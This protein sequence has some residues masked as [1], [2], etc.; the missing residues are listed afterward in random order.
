MWSHKEHVIVF[1]DGALLGG[2]KQLVDWAFREF[3]FEDY[4]PEALYKA[5]ADD[6]YKRR[7][8]DSGV[9]DLCH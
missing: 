7:I 6:A 3:G 1:K 2:L 5:F 4:R 9:S 8:K